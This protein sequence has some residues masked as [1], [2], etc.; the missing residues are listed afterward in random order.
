MLIIVRIW[1]NFKICTCPKSYFLHIPTQTDRLKC[2]TKQY[3]WDNSYPYIYIVIVQI[4]WDSSFS[5]LKNIWIWMLLLRNTTHPWFVSHKTI[6][7]ITKRIRKPTA[8]IASKSSQ[9]E[10]RLLLGIN[11][12]QLIKLFN[13]PAIGWVSIKMF[14]AIPKQ[15]TITNMQ[16]G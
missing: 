11:Q 4:Y 12:F 15:N 10:I 14:F 8:F 16:L 13:W 2:Q 1:T 6:G 7:N 5:F 3:Q 9:L